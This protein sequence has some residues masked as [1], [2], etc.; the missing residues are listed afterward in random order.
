MFFIIVKGLEVSNG[1]TSETGRIV[2]TNEDP[3]VEVGGSWY[4]LHSGIT[5]HSEKL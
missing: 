3:R 4:G 2:A 5:P 1:R